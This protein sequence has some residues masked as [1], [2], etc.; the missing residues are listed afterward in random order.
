M[1]RHGLA[2]RTLPHDDAVAQRRGRR[3]QL[4]HRA[5]RRPLGEGVS[6]E[7]VGAHDDAVHRRG[8][9][10]Q[11]RGQLGL[12]IVRDAEHGGAA[13]LLQR[14][15]QAL[16]QLGEVGLVQVGHDDG[17]AT[18]AP[19]HEAPSSHVDPVAQLLDGSQ[20]GRAGGL[21]RPQAAEQH[22]GHRLGGHTGGSTDVGQRRP[23]H[24]RT[25]PS[26]DSRRTRST[27]DVTTRGWGGAVPSSRSA[28]NS[29]ATRASRCGPGS[30]VVRAG[31]EK[32]PSSRLS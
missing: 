8:R 13:P 11:H 20:H 30:T 12:A 18:G 15:D 10:P 24:S 7:E 23:P 17:D 22:V 5:G 28:S 6:A 21:R 9:R 31:A 2:A 29:R 14:V 3:A 25:S 27:G 32:R 16:S 1:P 26:V 19:R 4:H